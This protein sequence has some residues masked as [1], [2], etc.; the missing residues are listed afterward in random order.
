LGVYSL[1]KGAVPEYLG[2]TPKKPAGDHRTYEFSGWLPSIAPVTK[3]A[4]Y[5]AQFSETLDSYDV[6]FRN[7][8]GTV[9]ESKK[10]EYGSTPSYSGAEPSRPSSAQYSFAFKGWYPDIAPVSGTADYEA[11]YS[12]SPLSEQSLDTIVFSAGENKIGTEPFVSPST[13]YSGSGHATTGLGVRV[14]FD[15]VSFSNP[16]TV[17]QLV[18]AG[19][20]FAN[21]DPI[22]GM[23]GITLSKANSTTGLQ[24]FWSETKT[25][26]SAKSAVY[27]ANSAATVTCDFG[28]YS[29]NYLKVVVIGTQKASIA[30]GSISCSWA[31]SYPML[32]LTNAN[33][34]FGSV[35]G[36]G[37]HK[38][39]SSVS[40]AATPK[41]GHSFGGWYDGGTLV[42]SA[43]PYAFAMPSGDLALEARFSSNKYTVTLSSSEVGTS[44][45][46]TC[47]VSGSGTYDYGSMVTISA[48]PASGYGFLGWYDGNTLVS[49]ANPYTFAIPANDVSYVAKY[50]KKY[51]VSV[52]SYDE[53][54]G[55][56]SGAGDFAYTSNTIVTGTPVKADQFNAITWYDD[57]FNPVSN[58]FTYTF[59]M[60]E[61]DVNLSA[62]FQ[63]ALGSSFTLGKYPQTVVENSSLL[64]ALEKARDTDSDGYLEYGSDEYK[65]V[66]GAPYGSGYKSA[67]GNVTFASGTTYYFKV[68]PIQWRVLSGKG[69][70]RGLVMAEKILT[71]SAYYTSTTN[72][73]ISGSTVYPN[74]Y[75]YS[76]LRAML[77]GLDGSSYSVANFSGNGFLDVAFTEAEKAHIAT[78]TVD[79]SAATTGSS[80]NSY[81]CANTSDRIFVLSYQDLIN[82]SYGFNSSRSNYDAARRGVLTDYARATGAWMST[83]SSYYGN[84][85][86]WSRSPD[87]RDSSYAW[88]VYYVGALDLSCVDF[89]RY[90]VRP[91]F[92]VSIG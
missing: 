10:W 80:S 88:D 44:P 38:V 62:D 11:A 87:A 75:Q 15:Y 84:N 57:S 71:N 49:S 82:T 56:V 7:Y 16:T 14:A 90:G 9:L 35:S 33:P 40:L 50:S 66:T 45:V 27:D 58:D 52:S 48:T 17:W 51:H 55:T 76:T 37:I 47:E 77:N 73:T 43:N 70:A 81:A 20:Y 65:K 2:E 92:T 53:K 74:N 8:D 5:V 25:F 91:S 59:A 23:K 46:G 12:P 86:W 6:V 89:A 21:A 30:S 1:E 41:T 32:T 28:G 26:D 72:R 29:P 79:N 31:N 34:D 68:E 4:M 18:A 83:D 3:N 19:G 85:C 67:S 36:G 13:L 22:Y 69:T 24:V 78:T 63:K 39:G 61:A 64:T 54:K 42:S 60:P